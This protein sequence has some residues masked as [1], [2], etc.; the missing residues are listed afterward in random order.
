MCEFKSNGVAGT[1][2]GLAWRPLQEVRCP[3][4]VS[5][6]DMRKH[7]QAPKAITRLDTNSERYLLLDP[8][9]LMALRKPHLSLALL[10]SLGDAKMWFSHPS[11]TANAWRLD[12]PPPDPHSTGTLLHGVHFCLVVPIENA[13]SSQYGRAAE[14]RGQQIFRH[15]CGALARLKRF[16]LKEQIRQASAELRKHCL[17]YQGLWVPRGSHA[18]AMLAYLSDKV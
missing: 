5:R 11:D 9:D 14:S 6:F 4:T 3:L 7:D 12:P 10:F 1:P 13:G 8:S 15:T 16:C 17:R 2:R 18:N